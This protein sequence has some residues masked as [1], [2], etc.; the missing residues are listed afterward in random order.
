MDGGPLPDP[1]AEVTD[2]RRAA[3]WTT[4]RV[5]AR[6]AASFPPEQRAEARAVL[7]GYA[8]SESGGERVQLA[9]LWLA[10]GDLARLR[11]LVEQARADSRDVLYWA[12]RRRTP[13]GARRLIG[14][15]LELR[16][17]DRDRAT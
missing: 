3:D 14:E 9:C 16:R 17:A 1:W 6:V 7:D 5:A 8:P 12:S 13:E 4:E 10:Q 15:I 2:L 11:W